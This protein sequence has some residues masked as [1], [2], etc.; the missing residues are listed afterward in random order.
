[1]AG[2]VQR[3]VGGGLA[4]LGRGI[5]E[6]AQSTRAET[7]AR[8]RE[9]GAARRAQIQADQRTAKA[10]ADADQAE[11][12]RQARAREGDL[13]RKSRE[14]VAGMRP[15]SVRDKPYLLGED[16]VTGKKTYG[17]YEQAMAT[18]QAA[19]DQDS[20]AE[21]DAAAAERSSI[22]PK[23]LGGE[24]DPSD[25]QLLRAYELKR[26][27]PGMTGKEA[28]MRAM[29]GGEGDGQRAGGNRP[30]A[31][32]GSPTPPGRGTTQEPYEVSTQAH[33]NWLRQNAQSGTV[34]RYNGKLNRVK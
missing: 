4:G 8:I 20:A 5:V 9:A 28:L 7:L 10:Q 12:D 33:V 29:R 17:D 27:N 2:L 18:G 6:Q 19:A 32:S 25:D 24:P 23:F 3:V 13:D 21:V 16:P 31:A 26:T 14:K 34:Y 1:M 15:N 11:R 22:L 30:P